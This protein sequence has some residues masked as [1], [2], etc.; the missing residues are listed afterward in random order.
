MSM[1]PLSTVLLA[2]FF[3]EGD[4]LTPQRMAGIGIGFLGVVIL[5]GPTVLEGIGDDALRQLAIALAGISYAVATIIARKMPQGNILGRSVGIMLA[6][7]LM[8]L[9][10]AIWLDRPMDIEP[11]TTALIGAIHLGLLP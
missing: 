8:L 10:F 7:F 3:T 9:P 1:M 2:H 5:V 6:G 11:S 4:R